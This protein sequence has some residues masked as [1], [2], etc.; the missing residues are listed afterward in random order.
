MLVYVASRFNAVLA[1]AVGWVSLIAVPVFITG[2]PGYVVGG[3]PFLI[4]L[5]GSALVLGV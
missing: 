1:T 3:E 2:L 4:Y 5:I